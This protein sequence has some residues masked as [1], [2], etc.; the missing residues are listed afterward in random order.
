MIL[1]KKGTLNAIGTGKEYYKDVAVPM[2]GT[3]TGNAKELVGFFLGA[4]WR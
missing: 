4:F 3:S 1:R 2:Q